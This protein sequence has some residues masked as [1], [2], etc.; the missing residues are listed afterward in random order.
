MA[1]ASNVE[2]HALAR[3]SY[4]SFKIQ[5]VVPRMISFVQSNSPSYGEASARKRGL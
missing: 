5:I 3:T 2:N 1:A 4:S